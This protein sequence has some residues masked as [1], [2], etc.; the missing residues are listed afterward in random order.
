MESMGRT[1][2]EKD[3][4][5]FKEIQFGWDREHK[6]CTG[7]VQMSGQGARSCESGRQWYSLGLFLK[8]WGITLRF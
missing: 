3:G 6:S 7:C 1:G 5:P 8:A 2:I 4:R